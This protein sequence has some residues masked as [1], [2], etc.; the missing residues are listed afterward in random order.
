MKKNVRLVM[1]LPI[2]LAL[3]FVGCN[4]DKSTGPSNNAPVNIPFS[5]QASWCAGY[6]PGVI[7]VTQLMGPSGASTT[8][9][10]PGV[11][12]VKGTY[13]LTG[14]AYTTAVIQMSFLGSVVTADGTGSVAQVP[15]T[16]T[17]ANLSGTFE[18]RGGF[19]QLTSG[20]GTPG[21]M[22]ASGSSALDCVSLQ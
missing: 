14:T 6:A 4:S 16:V 18:A 12:V 3:T 17:A 15:Y 19:L 11:W 1:S 20:P 2:A 10:L 8:N 21:V 5:S 7:H 22:I 9:V 13:T